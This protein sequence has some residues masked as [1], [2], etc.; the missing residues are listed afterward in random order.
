MFLFY[1][2]A[3]RYF[4]NHL[5]D[6]YSLDYNYLDHFVIVLTIMVF[7]CSSEGKVNIALLCAS[8]TYS[9]KGN[10]N[11]GFLHLFNLFL[12]EIFKLHTNR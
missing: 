5:I 7:C 2:P 9:N 4:T 8:S 6:S 11:N 3:M 12:E 10:K 1:V